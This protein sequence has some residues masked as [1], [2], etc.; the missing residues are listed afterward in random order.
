M[1]GAVARRTHFCTMGAIADIVASG[2]WTRM[3]MWVLAIATAMIGFN[4]MVAA[5]WVQAGDSLYATP[6]LAWLAHVLGGLLFGF[7]MVLASGCPNRTLVRAGGGNLKAL[8]VLL[9][10]GVSASMT[11]RG[12]VAVLRVA[13][14]ERA[15]HAGREQ[16]HGGETGQR[17]GIGQ[18]DTEHDCLVD[19]S[20]TN[21]RARG[22]EGGEA[23]NTGIGKTVAHAPQTHP[24][25]DLPTERGTADGHGERRALLLE[26]ADLEG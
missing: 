10:L 13:S 25:G 1:F 8:V 21:Q 19:P 9:V 24:F 11:M 18:F 15:A 16:F 26:V 2:D 7:G 22:V 3:R 17:A 5:G 23:G 4:A 6:R 20:G 12:L 14:V